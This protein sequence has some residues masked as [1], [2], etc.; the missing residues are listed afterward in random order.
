MAYAQP[1]FAAAVQWPAAEGVS[2]R[3]I[4]PDDAE[5]LQAY[6]RG[7][8]TES[9]YKRFFGA[10]QELPPAE[11]EHVTRLDRK[12]DVALLAEVNIG[13]VSITVGEARHAFVPDRRECEF[14]L[15][16]AD[17]WRH[18]GIGTLLLAEMERRARSLGARRLTAES[19]RSNEEMKALAHKNGFRMTDVP[20]DARLVRI[21][22]D[23]APPQAAPRWR[24][25]GRSPTV[26]LA[27]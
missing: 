11:L 9:R 3:P 16:V 21:V 10:L 18:R 23:L 12:Y 2:L 24:Q 6:V 25:A 5:L 4:T 17:A 20:C 13:G 27:A 19:L 8:S 7:L 1:G 15:S 26:P 22:K 14:A